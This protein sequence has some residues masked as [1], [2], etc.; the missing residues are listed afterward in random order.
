MAAA[1]GVDGSDL[2]RVVVVVVVVV[3]ADLAVASSQSKVRLLRS[4]ERRVE[5]SGEE[6]ASGEEETE[7]GANAGG[8]SAESLLLSLL[9]LFLGLEVVKSVMTEEW[10]VKTPRSSRAAE[11]AR[12]RVSRAESSFW[13]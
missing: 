2:G 10:E 6:A 1:T 13:S 11:A 7:A 5:V 9:V 3:L 4:G 8:D 12:E